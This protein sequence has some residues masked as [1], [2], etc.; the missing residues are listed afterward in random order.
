[1]SG[2]ESEKSR[3]TGDYIRTTIRIHSLRTRGRVLGLSLL[4]LSPETLPRL[5]RHKP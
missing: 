4:Q 1:M 2:E 5:L 3:I